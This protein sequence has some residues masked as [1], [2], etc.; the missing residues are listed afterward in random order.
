MRIFFYVMPTRIYIE[1]EVI[2][3][4]CNGS[5]DAFKI[6]FGLMGNKVWNYCR[7][8]TGK[9]EDAEELVQDIFTKLWQYRYQIDPAGNFEVFVFTLARNHIYNFGRKK[10]QYQ[11]SPSGTLSEYNLTSGEPSLFSYQE[12]YQQYR[13]VLT[14]ISGRSQQVFEMSREQGLSH[15][16]IADQL[17]ISIRTVENHIFNALKVLKRELK[18]YYILL[19]L[20]TFY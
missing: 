7:K 4:F 9:R 16:E 15:K 1:P 2:E 14:Q 8:L 13:K 11:L 6:I 20:L 10:L 12:I 3:R 5:E 17:G 19:V 18:D